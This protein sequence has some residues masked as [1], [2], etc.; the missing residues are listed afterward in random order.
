MVYKRYIKKGEKLYGPYEYHSRKKD[1]KVISEYLGKELKKERKRN[2]SFFVAI[3]FLLVLLV[4]SNLFLINLSLTG[5]V[6]LSMDKT[7]LPGEQILG[8]AKLSLMKGELLPA[9]TKLIINNGGE[10]SEFLLKDLI[11][12]NISI[13]N[14]YVEDKALSGT[15]EGYG[16][17][18]EKEIY[19]DVDFTLL[20]YKEQ[21][22]ETSEE[23]EEVP[24]IPE[25]IQNETEE[26]IPE[27]E[28]EIQDN[29]T[30]KIKQEDK[31]IAKEGISEESNETS[32]ENI[33]SITG[34]IIGEYPYEIEGVVSKNSPFNYSLNED[35]TAE[36]ESFGK[37]VELKIK[38][39]IAIVTTDYS[40]TEKGYGEEYLGNKGF[41][42]E[43]D[44]SRLNLTAKE[45]EFVISLVYEEIE[46]V[47]LSKDITIKEI[48][49]I[50]E[51]EVIDEIPEF[52]NETI[53]EL[54]E[55]E[56]N[57]TQINETIILGDI[58]ASINTTQY[59]AV[60]GM[61]VKWKKKI[62]LDEP[63]NITIELPKEAQNI[64][65]YKIVREEKNNEEEINETNSD[66]KVNDTD[67]E[68]I[69]NKTETIPEIN[70][71]N[72]TITGKISAQISF[73]KESEESSFFDFFKKIF[74]SITG[75]VTDIDETADS[76][77]VNI[78]EN[79]SEYEI[80]YSTPAPVLYEKDLG[81]RKEITVSSEM[82]YEKI[83]S[84]TEL[85]FPAEKSK[86]KLYHIENGSLVLTE[87]DA[88][89]SEGNLIENSLNVAESVV[90]NEENETGNKSIIYEE[91]PVGKSLQDLEQNQS[92]NISVSEI[93]TNSSNN[94]I[95]IP[96]ESLVSFITWIVPYLS[97]Q[98]YI[99]VIEAI[100]AEH[101]DENR[102]FISDIYNET[103]T[104]DFV[105]SPAVNN[106]QYVRVTF[107]ENLTN[108]NDITIYA[109][110]NENETGEISV[111]AKD[112]EE[113]ITK[114]E[115]ISSENWYKTYLTGLGE[116]YDNKTE[117]L[118]E[119]GWK[120]FYD[121]E[122]NEEVATL[123]PETKELEW[124][125]PQEQQEFDYNKEMYR[126]TLE[127]GSD[128]LV[129]EKHRVYSGERDYTS[130]KFLNSF[131]LNILTEDCLLKPDSLDQIAQ[132]NF[133]ASANIG[134]SLSYINCLA[135]DANCLN[136]SLGIVSIKL[137]NS[138][139]ASL[140][141]SDLS[142]EYFNI[143]DSLFFNSS[144]EYSGAN[145]FNPKSSELTIINLTGLSLK[146]ETNM[147][148]STTNCIYQPSDLY[149]F[150]AFS[151]TSF[152]NLRQSSSV[153]SEFDNI[154]S[155]FL[156]NKA[157]L[158]FS[159]K[160]LRIDSERFNSG[161]SSICFFNSSDIDS[162]MFGILNN[163]V[164]SVEDVQLF[165]SFSL[166]PIT[167]VYSDFENGEEIYF[168]NA[169]N[170]PLKIK[171]I[172]KENYNG[173]IY[174]V[175]V[176][177]DI[178]LV[179]RNNGTALWSGNSNS[180][181]TFDLKINCLSENC[182]G[183]EFDYI[184][185]PFYYNLSET[186][187]FNVT[188]LTIENETF[189]HLTIT[190]G[191]LVGY[192]PFDVQEN[193]AENKTYDYT[194]NSNDGTLTGGVLFNSTG[195]FNG[196]G[197]YQFDG[198]DDYINT[199]N[200]NSLNLSTAITVSAWIYDKGPS[201]TYRMIASKPNSWFMTVY[202]GNLYCAV[203]NLTGTPKQDTTMGAISVNTWMHVVM[204][205]NGTDVFSYIN[206]T[207]TDK[208]SLGSSNMATN[209]NSVLIGRRNAGEVFNGSLDEV[210]VF[211]RSLSTTEIYNIFNSTY[212]RFYP[213]A[214][215][216]FKSQIIP[217]GNES[218]TW[219][220]SGGGQ[221]YN[222]SQLNARVGYWDISKAY[223]FSDL[224]GN[225]GLVGYWTMDYYNS[226][227]IFDN[228]TSGNFGTFKGAAFGTSNLTTGVYN[229]SLMFDGVD[230]YVDL[231]DVL[232]ITGN[233]SVSAWVYQKGVHKGGYGIVAGKR[234][235]SSSDSYEMVFVGD[236]LWFVIDTGT[237]AFSSKV[238]IPLNQWHHLVGTWNGTDI[239]LYYDG[240]VQ[241]DTDP[242]DGSMSDVA[243][244][245]IIGGTS[246]NY[247][248]NGSIDD[249][250][251]FNRSLSSDEI[252]E[253]YLKGRVNWEYSDYVNYSN[254]V[255]NEITSTSTNILP[256]IRY[257]ASPNNFYS[258]V[259]IGDIANATYDIIL[260]SLSD[261]VVPSVTI[262]S[263]ANN[264]YVSS[265]AKFDANINDNSGSTY[266]F[267]NDTSL[268]GYWTFDTTN[269]TGILDTS[270]RN[271]F[272]TFGAG[273]GLGQSNLSDGRFGDSL[274]FDGVN[275]YVDL[276]NSASINL[277]GNLTI[278][279]WVKPLEGNVENIL[280]KGN[281][282][283]SS[284]GSFG[285]AYLDSI[286][287]F[288]Y[289]IFTTNG[290]STSRTAL[291]EPASKG[292]W[293][294]V[295]L[296]YNGTLGTYLNSIHAGSSATTYTN[297]NT[298]SDDL[299]LGFN[300]DVNWFNG[301]IDE[302]LIFNRSLST[303]EVKALYNSSAQKFNVSYTL[304]SIGANNV[305][306]LA[307][308]EAENINLTLLNL[309]ND[310]TKPSI[311]FISPTLDSG[312]STGDNYFIIN[313]SITDDYTSDSSAWFDWNKSLVGYW[314][315]DYYNSTGIFDNS[316]YENNGTFNG[317]LGTSNL[318]QGA[319]G[320]GLMFDGVDDYIIIPL[321]NVSTLSE[322]WS[323]FSWINY[324]RNNAV[325]SAIF[326]TQLLYLK[327]SS[328]GLWSY[329]GVTARTSSVAL[330]EGVWANVGVTCDNRTDN[331]TFYINGV[332]SGSYS[333]NCD[334]YI[335]N[336]VNS[337]G[338][339]GAGTY[340]FNGSLDEVMIFNRSLS[341]S[342]ISALYNNSQYRLQNNFTNLADGAT[343]NYSVYAVDSAGNLNITT[344]DRQ[345][346]VD[347]IFPSV[348]VSYP[349]N[350]SYAVNV[351]ELNYTIT[352]T[353]EDY[354]WYSNDSGAVNSSIVNAGENFT[355]VISIEGANEWV[356]YCNDTSGNENSS[357]VTFFKDSLNP[358][359]SIA[360]PVEGNTYTS[361]SVTFQVTTNEN[362]TCNYSVNSGATN[363][364]MTA[365][366]NGTIHTATTTLSNANYIADY[367]CSDL[368][369]N[370]N[371]TENV[372]F[373][374]SVSTAGTG[375]TGG[376]TGGGGG[377]TAAS[378]VKEISVGV[379]SIERTLALN[380]IEIGEFYIE[381]LG[382][383]P[384][385]FDISVETI[386]SI[387]L[388]EQTSLEILPGEKEKIEFRLT[389]PKETGIYTGK[390]IVRSGSFK[391]EIPVTIN[392]KT[393]KSL[394]DITVLIPSFMKSLDQNSNLEAQ[395]DLL[396][397]GIKEKMDV[398]LNYV[399]KDFEGVVHLTES[400]TIAVENQKSIIKEFPTSELPP[401]DYVLGVELLYPDGVA[402]ASSQFK[403]KGG[404]GLDREV[405]LM[406]VLILALLLVLFAVFL[407]IKK[408]R[409]MLKIVKKGRKR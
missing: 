249:V 26:E 330:T 130:R 134:T 20:I 240:G 359:V 310:N 255:E 337:I 347:L 41:K 152:P 312:D 135:L 237:A 251:V 282:G 117:I 386:N 357:S 213:S 40:E 247:N 8:S 104:Q 226:T 340:P 115:N 294:H 215:Q 358:E 319:R 122:G 316:S 65:V 263:P 154:S 208:F 168:L 406:V 58:I 53:I 201:P 276:E 11:D 88:Y 279:L 219:S 241:V 223:N 227:G 108:T 269:S 399:V 57:E 291:Y 209:T 101:L 344:P 87:F 389:P 70:Q 109:R 176:E 278:S 368:Y 309:T 18:G 81:K 266:A 364:S 194:N 47:S 90:L 124:Q 261:D 397:M 244:N 371:N 170:K 336:R 133:N 96:N 149:F 286:D 178:V 17:E 394:F 324:H 326:A 396:Q 153:N 333:Y 252:K 35:E 16:I 352:D 2:N 385:T 387:L 378:S 407:V 180:Y 80:E 50:N 206:G 164:Y 281:L 9:S 356:V 300:Y 338:S 303:D 42:F 83:L 195:G 317:G 142:F 211:N 165:K 404:F 78:D 238:D 373:I 305:Q 113:L 393:E 322:G 272:G 107:E 169:E 345:I 172:T 307:V 190:D 37:E 260:T 34:G 136:N 199:T 202:G 60:V 398:T 383:V 89:D 220:L 132:P 140:N 257:L 166:Q 315:M 118:T 94:S 151:F 116:C 395:I 242:K 12:E 236:D 148:V 400:E 15:G 284:L 3:L 343:Y 342:E 328:N 222:G 5:K 297:L 73:G 217:A 93:I 302:V 99:L 22:E 191:S 228:S 106:S 56:L 355:E 189:G 409:R 182:T 98:T 325:Y 84:Y 262:S 283:S 51:S 271:N 139:K 362:S 186:A 150:Q 155:N 193:I 304:P 120:Y 339:F 403:I 379:S 31:E 235:L 111:Y 210:M 55:T 265:I 179:K 341:S 212:S 105:W 365:N 376:N 392:I 64:T 6:S 77:K 374:V 192:W 218:A 147:L 318:T 68:T 127:D 91:N 275:D 44:L 375:T 74:G 36:I 360:L 248:F 28:Q 171:S 363:N 296:T 7:S 23:T 131:V 39:N 313:T 334:Y 196:S 277:S 14:F 301:S 408:Y 204:V 233:I 59:G 230:D 121:L 119:N 24:E 205:F 62:V 366:T 292:V 129:S 203:W 256:E 221:A 167:E 76:I 384:K 274:M 63:S 287:N 10:K 314:A 288:G 349:E 267:I 380:K 183:I 157:L 173:K 323:A 97:N 86:V 381:N 146:N 264:S 92:S 280:S 246:S 163:S 114:I 354:C 82:H 49:E 188:N 52:L 335:G 268:V 184:V 125:L 45:G 299:R 311:E 239:I 25:E 27:E 225:N 156:S 85:N 332:P 245:L 327:N 29:I 72:M 372:S 377:G 224:N 144:I 46:L 161:N 273:T 270:G 19:P 43:L 232:D 259:A 177:N 320:Q 289:Y 67:K 390:I 214:V 185:D 253:I 123:N 353:N 13:G 32:A 285:I 100:G 141:C 126:I 162:V 145:N 112:S 367:Y 254:G 295:V 143:S 243:T 200:S 231:G 33:L 48:Q 350:T 369:G 229:N 175:D 198:V 361:S 159:D 103:K 250:M 138:G 234:G 61:P 110:A 321:I 370:Q 30:K 351:S 290:S 79:A 329:D 95:I 54:N 187:Q 69:I 197:A 382:V 331:L 75:K 38:D 174:D 102:S 158:T 306:L 128:L 21:T 405:I 137:D 391:Q 181:D 388:L 258:P 298:N 1:G 346:S 160:N 66:E 401:G 402:V 4:A 348:N 308:D 207:Y 71:E 216:T 293:S